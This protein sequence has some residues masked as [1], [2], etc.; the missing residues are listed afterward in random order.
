MHAVA[1]ATA[2][3]V[4]ARFPAGLQTRSTREVWF[5]YV[6]KTIYSKSTEL[7]TGRKFVLMM[8]PDHKKNST[9]LYS[10]S[11]AL[12]GAFY[13]A[14]RLKGQSPLRLKQALRGP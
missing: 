12:S 14:E 3:F 8:Y 1:L 11:A 6:S 5:K 4:R 7:Q 9:L 2:V 13:A 10:G